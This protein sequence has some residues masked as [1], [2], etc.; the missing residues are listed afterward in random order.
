MTKLGATL[1]PILESLNLTPARYKQVMA[2]ASAGAFFHCKL[3]PTMTEPE[4]RVQVVGADIVVT[5]PGSSY[6][7]AYYKPKS[8]PSLLMRYSTSED[9]LRIA[10]TGGEFLAQAWKLANQKARE[11][12]WI[13]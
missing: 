1:R 7:V 9:D 6:A 8:S 13:V 3:K 4:L 12:G 11:L 2:L 10:M 5:L